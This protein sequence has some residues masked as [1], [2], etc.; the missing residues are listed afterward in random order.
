[1][2]TSSTTR[3]SPDQGSAHSRAHGGSRL[4]I[5]A[6]ELPIGIG[7]VLGGW[8]MLLDPLHP[9]GITPALLDGTPFGDYVWPGFLLVALVGVPALVLAPALLARIRGAVLLSALYGVGLMAWIVVQW[10][11]ID[12]RQW[13]QPVIF[14]VAAVVT[15]TA[16]WAWHRGAR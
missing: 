13:L 4:L 16:G 9:L 3:R 2:A 15:V 12:D 11:L 5:A 6:L 14:G 8:Q 10:V 1:M 7:A